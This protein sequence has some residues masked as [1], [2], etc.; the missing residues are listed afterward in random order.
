MNN[1]N[2]YKINT[3]M[4]VRNAVRLMSE[5]RM[6]LCVCVDSSDK[7]IGVF[8]LG[9]FRKAVFLEIQL[10]DRV[11]ALVNNNFKFV[12]KGYSSQEVVNIFNDTV[13]K[14]IPI[15]DDNRLVG[16]IS[17]D[18][19]SNEMVIEQTNSLNNPVVIMAGG[20]GSRLDPFTKILPKP[21]IPFGDDPVI[22]VIMDEFGKFGMHNFHIALNANNMM[23]KAY[24][25]DHA[26]PHTI[27]YIKEL[28]P[29]GTIGAVK[30]LEG[31]F[32]AP[33]FVTNCDI[34][35]HTNY[36][37]ALDFHIQGGYDLTLISAIY[38]LIVPYGVCNV[39]KKGSLKSLQEKPNYD[40]LVNTGFYILNP[41]VFPYI[42]HDEYFDATDL[43]TAL[44]SDNRSIGV[45]PVTEHDWIDVGQWSEYHKAMN[46]L[47]GLKER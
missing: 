30:F 13:V 41:D 2:R 43:I 1:L 42:P 9:D 44:K 24:F 15:L 33:F 34:I 39:E 5:E 31:K 6:D 22:K 46:K 7:V 47:E 12:V 32:D 29:L 8:T 38:N 26:L 18:D 16:M 35:M 28:K 10:D 4:T 37:S 11:E 3:S 27:E 20:R 45:F 40:F 17:R 36:A 14:E 25:H 23:I 19:F 21:L